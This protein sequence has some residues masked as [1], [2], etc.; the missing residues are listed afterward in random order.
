MRIAP[1]KKLFKVKE[2][3]KKLPKKLKNFSLKMHKCA[4]IEKK[5]KTFLNKGTVHKKIIFTV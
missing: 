1:K 5:T 4:G 2:C 3:Q